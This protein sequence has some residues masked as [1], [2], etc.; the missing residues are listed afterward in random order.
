MADAGEPV[1]VGKDEDKAATHLP[2][3]AN[4][5]LLTRIQAGVAALDEEQT[6]NLYI[7]LVQLGLMAE[8]HE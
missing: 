6:A 1:T 8:P 4:E 3:E 2:F 5:A 7:I